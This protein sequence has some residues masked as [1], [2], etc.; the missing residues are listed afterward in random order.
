MDTIGIPDF[1]IAPTGVM[2]GLEHGLVYVLFLK[3]QK[4]Q[5]RMEILLWIFDQIFVAYAV[6]DPG[7]TGFELQEFIGFV[8]PTPKDGRHCVARTRQDIGNKLL[9]KSVLAEL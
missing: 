4:V 3:T 5:D 7:E 1:W 8:E 9:H 6:A 2:S